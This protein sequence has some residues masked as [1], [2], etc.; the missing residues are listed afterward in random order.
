MVE[1]MGEIPFEGVKNDE[2]RTCSHS[3]KR[4]NCRF[5]NTNFNRA[6]KAFIMIADKTPD[7]VPAKMARFI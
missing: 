5:Y 1:Q 3:N 4:S 7:N 2:K 6:A